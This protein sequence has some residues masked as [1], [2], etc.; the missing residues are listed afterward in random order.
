MT[1]YIVGVDEAGC[2][3]L[4]GS[5]VV[6]AVAFAVDAPHVTA[7][8]KGIR[9][10]KELV[11]GDSKGFKDP[12]HRA[13]LAAAVRKASPAVAV[14][15][16]SAAEI[17]AR[18]FGT[19]FPEAVRLAA[20]RCLEHLRL[21]DP[22][23]TLADVEVLVDGDIARPDI[24]CRVQCIADGDKTIWQIGAASIIAKHEHDLCVDRLHADHPKWGFD[25]HRG[26]P[27][28]AHKALLLLRGPTPSHRRSFRPVAAVLPRAKGVEE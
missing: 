16:R 25:Q 28:P 22:A 3:A 13:I 4:A 23:L 20:S 1:R 14:I 12:A 27:T 24:P 10:D 17:D 19:V 18:L 21:V 9:R 5:L 15:A 11:V 7:I 6:A 2:G 26:Y 8:W